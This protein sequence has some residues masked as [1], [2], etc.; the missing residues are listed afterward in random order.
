MEKEFGFEKLLVY[1]KSKEYVRTIY[2]LLKQFPAEERYAMC[3]QLRRASVSVSSNI[4]EG[5]SRGTLKEKIHFLDI[6]FGSLMET[7]SQMDIA[8][9]LQYINEEE[10]MQVREQCL[11]VL[12][13]LAGLKKSYETVQEKQIT[14]SLIT[15][16][17]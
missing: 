16:N 10:L 17:R 1:Q 15:D 9:D 8:K 13:L 4:A 5:T 7:Y 14:E 12:K 6:A 3:D 11:A 2:S